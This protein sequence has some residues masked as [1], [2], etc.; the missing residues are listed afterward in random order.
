MAIK[1][2]IC[3][4]FENQKI[5][6]ALKGLFCLYICFIQIRIPIATKVRQTVKS[7]NSPTLIHFA[8]KLILCIFHY[9]FLMVDVIQTHKIQIVRQFNLNK[10]RTKNNA[11]L[12]RNLAQIT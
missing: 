6:S 7:L 2:Q 4:F 12:L 3:A 8:R 5:R 10:L 11:H 1:H 9:N